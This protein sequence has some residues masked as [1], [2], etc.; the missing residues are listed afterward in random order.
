MKDK[1]FRKKVCR[2]LECIFKTQTV[3]VMPGLVTVLHICYLY[4]EGLDLSLGSKMFVGCLL[5]MFC[6]WIT[7][8]VLNWI[9][10]DIKKLVKEDEKREEQNL[11]QEI[12]AQTC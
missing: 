10:E 8:I 1:T 11:Y 4:F 7:Y 3:G 12:K 5:T 9:L 6:V 2:Y